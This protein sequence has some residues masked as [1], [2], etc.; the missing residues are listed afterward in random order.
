MSQI[1]QKLIEEYVTAIRKIY[2]THLKQVILY[3][4]YARGDFRTDSDVDIM[5][6][7]DLPEDRLDQFSDALSE[8]GF[9]YN[10]DHDVWFMPVVKNIDHFHYWCQAYPF[11][12][13]VAKEGISIYE[14]A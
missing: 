1:M 5:L 14:A 8:L 2:G 6:L 11:Y 13:N 3:G 10:V 7:V 9:D 12:S 4:S